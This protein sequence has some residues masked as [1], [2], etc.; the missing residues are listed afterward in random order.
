MSKRKFNFITPEI[1]ISIIVAMILLGVGLYSVLVVSTNT[2]SNSAMYQTTCFNVKGETNPVVER[3]LPSLTSGIISV[4]EYYDDG[5]SSTIDSG[6]YSWR[7][8][9]PTQISFN[10]TGG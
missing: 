3:T 5:A 6:N 9:S 8:S 4:T 1:M 2:S 7:S 10:I